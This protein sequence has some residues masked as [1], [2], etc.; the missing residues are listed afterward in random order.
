M[1][2]VFAYL[3][4]IIA[5][6]IVINFFMLFVRLKRNKSSKSSYPAAPEAKAAVHRHREIQRRLDREQEE[7]A[8]IVEMRNKTFEIYAQVRKQAAQ[9][10]R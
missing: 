7:L 4:A 9:R 6:V 2:T 3:V 5:F 8:H 1:N 10:D